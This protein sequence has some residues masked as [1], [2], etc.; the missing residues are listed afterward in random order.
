M[1]S[2]VAGRIEIAVMRG[3]ET[4]GP[5]TFCQSESIV[6]RAAQ[7]AGLAGGIEA[8]HDRQM[9]HGAFAKQPLLDLYGVSPSDVIHVRL[10]TW[11]WDNGRGNAGGAPGVQWG[12]KKAVAMKVR[13]KRM[14]AVLVMGVAVVGFAFR[15]FALSYPLSSTAIRDAYFLGNDNNE[16]T[17]EFLAQ[18]IHRLPQPKSGA[19]VQEIGID[20]PF[21]QIVWQTRG[22][23]NYFAPDAVQDFQNKR[24][25]FLV[26]VIVAL[27]DM[28]SPIPPTSAPEYYQ[29]VPDFWNDFK[30]QL[31]QDHKQIAAEQ[32]RGGPIY[33]YGEG[34]I[35]M[36]TGAMILLL[37]NPEKIGANSTRIVVI[38]PDGQT[39][40][41]TFNLAKLR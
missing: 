36:V 21:T 18:Y 10:A 6:H 27:T 41:T 40:E 23:L 5:A 19:Y 3:T 22:K 37:Y 14:A 32:T 9:L 30:V 24:M 33:S 15:V 25:P 20:T 34:E 39:V 29:W 35:P 4:A 28:Y 11:E 26:H 13:T 7:R 17:G 8:I 12:R 38:S 2:N 1:G 16:R 31:V